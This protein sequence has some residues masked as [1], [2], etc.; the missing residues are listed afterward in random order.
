MEMLVVRRNLQQDVVD[1]LRQAILSGVFV[2]GNRLVE[3]DL[4]QR[5]GISRPSLREALRSLQAERLIEII[6]NKGP[7]IPTLSL[8]DAEAI[9]EVREL[10]EGEAAAR[11]ALAITDAQT[12]ELE[13]SLRDFAAATH[14][15]DP[16]ARVNTASDFYSKIMRNS[17]NTVLQEIHESLLARINFLRSRSMSLPQRSDESLKE[18]T[19]VFE[20]IRA[21]DP[22]LS[23]AKAQQH[24]AS[25]R[26]AALET[27]ALDEAE[28]KKAGK[29]RTK[30]V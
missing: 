21:R 29:R 27:F 25:A 11:C 15:V 20:A 26:R 8:R 23:K 1:K 14:S 3:S 9:Y 18:M 28:E 12:V 24:V 6:P 13:A 30:R 10:L 22:A 2:P 17:G 4:C 19:E 7:Q 16:I 5:L